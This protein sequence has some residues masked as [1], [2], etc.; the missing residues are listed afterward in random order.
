MPISAGVEGRESLRINERDSRRNAAHCRHEPSK[1]SA[2]LTRTRI[3][4]KSENGRP[5]PFHADID[6]GC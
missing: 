2:N 1:T 5:A 3:G 6:K 4:V